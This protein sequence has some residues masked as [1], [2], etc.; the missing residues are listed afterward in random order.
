MRYRPALPSEW[1]ACAHCVRDTFLWDEPTRP[2]LLALWQHLLQTGAGKLEIIE[3]I[4]GLPER[5]I[6][7]VCFKMYGDTR[8]SEFLH[9]DGV[10]PFIARRLVHHHRNNKALP[11][12]SRAALAR[13]N[14][15]HGPGITLA[16]LN[17]GYPPW[18]VAENKQHLI[19]DKV[20]EFSVFSCSGYHLNEFFFELYGAFEHRWGAGAGMT[21][22]TDYAPHADAHTHGPERAPQ[23]WGMKRAAT[24]EAYAGNIAALMFRYNPPRFGFT[25]AERELLQFA[26]DGIFDDEAARLLCLSMNTIK[27][28]WQSIFGRVEAVAPEIFAQAGFPSSAA[29]RGGD[30]KRRLL[31]YVRHHIEEL[32]PVSS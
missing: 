23:L 13:C 4:N 11:L 32:R 17:S 25:D 1:E 18:I 2:H 24:P 9:H 21:L 3:D 31:Q 28:R 15:P 29:T 6:V 12:L 16:V 22:R 7:W 8:L 19:L 30:R 5:R 14:A 26:Y 20:A 27:K 10:P